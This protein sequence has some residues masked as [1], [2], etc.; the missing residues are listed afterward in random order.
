MKPYTVAYKPNG[1]YE[2][3]RSIIVLANTKQEAWDKAV[4]EAIPELEGGMPYSAW[5]ERVT[6]NN[7]RVKEFNT[8][9]GLPY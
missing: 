4:F 8:C 1:A 9:E 7:G 2:T 5:V 3:Q 6:Y